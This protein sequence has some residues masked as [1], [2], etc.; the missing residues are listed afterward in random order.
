MQSATFGGIPALRN[1]LIWLIGAGLAFQL[2][3][4]SA[5]EQGSFSGTLRIGVLPDE[6]K[7][8]LLERYTPLLEF[9][10]QKIGH[11]CEIV[12]PDNY[13]E[14]LKLFGEG[15]IDLAYFGGATFV[16]ANT[17]YD[18]VPL[19]M[20]DV[21]T[22]FTSDL[23]VA[24]EDL[25]SL[26]EIQGKRFSFGSRLSTSG[27]LMPRHFLHVQHGVTPEKYFRSVQ[28]SGKHD[29][30]AYLVRDGDADAGVMN[31]EILR[32]MFAD[33]RLRPGDIRVIWT[34]PPYNDYVWAAHPHIQPLDREKIQQ[35]FL[36]LSVD[37]PQHKVILANLGA[38]GFYPASIRDSST[39][40]QVMVDLGML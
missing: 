38:A 27:H 21:D 11:P 5:P 23:V 15:Q 26:K 28:Y 18:A 3:A 13:D 22:R 35:A 19:I 7:K 17:E 1:L 24:G 32:K 40:K 33:G 34:T 36:Q 9:L 20:R 31:S 8:S 37:N 30:T 10:T 39:L 14:L 2:S 25:K 16:K 12:I 6:S 29:R 4:C